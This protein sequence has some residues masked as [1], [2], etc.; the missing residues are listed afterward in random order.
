MIQ[1]W[2]LRKSG[3]TEGEDTTQFEGSAE[4]EREMA[5]RGLVQIDGE[6]VEIDPDDVEE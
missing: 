5:E 3:G 4:F 1:F 2:E 6:W